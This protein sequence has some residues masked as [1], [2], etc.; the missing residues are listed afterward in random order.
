MPKSTEVPNL[1]RFDIPDDAT[2]KLELRNDFG[3]VIDEADTYDISIFPGFRKDQPSNLSDLEIARQICGAFTSE[4]AL[5]TLGEGGEILG[6][7]V[8]VIGDTVI[9]TG[10]MKNDRH[11]LWGVVAVKIKAGCESIAVVSGVGDRETLQSSYITIVQSLD[12]LT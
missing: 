1:F 4:T 6:Y 11:E 12:I 8:R 3:H 10:E 2:C 9:A 7:E 5:P